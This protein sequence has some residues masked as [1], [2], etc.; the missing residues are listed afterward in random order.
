MEKIRSHVTAHATLYG[1]A[2]VALVLFILAVMYV[3]TYTTYTLRT[4]IK[5]FFLGR[6]EGFQDQNVVAGGANIADSITREH[7]AKLKEQIENYDKLKEQHKGVPIANLD[8]TLDM[9]KQLFVSYN[10]E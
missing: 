6:R 1:A 10:C 5:S 2:A 4:K 3:D 9:M 7:C 8:E